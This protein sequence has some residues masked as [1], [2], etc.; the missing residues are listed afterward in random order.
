M[1]DYYYYIQFSGNL[2]ACFKLFI[3]INS[4][5]YYYLSY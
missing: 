2:L 5:K 3:R 1:L 4:D